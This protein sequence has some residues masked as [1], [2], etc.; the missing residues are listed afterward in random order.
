[1][2]A[3]LDVSQAEIS[4]LKLDTPL[5]ILAMDVT[6]DVSKVEISPAKLDAP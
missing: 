3:T 4:P 6:L 1:M 5:N 2:D